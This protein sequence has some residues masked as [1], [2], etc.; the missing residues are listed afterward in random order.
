MILYVLWKWTQ[1]W[2][3]QTNDL[4]EYEDERCL[5]G[6]QAKRLLNEARTDAL[7][8]VDISDS[9]DSSGD[10]NSD[11]ISDDNIFVNENGKQ[12]MMICLSN[13][14]FWEIFHR[15]KFVAV[16]TNFSMHF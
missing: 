16:L 10:D 13:S 8:T 7:M 6:E 15:P 9:E 11:E 2:C 3:G 1:Q 4:E 5:R 12:L 14:N